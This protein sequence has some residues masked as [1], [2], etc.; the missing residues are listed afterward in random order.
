VIYFLKTFYQ[1]DYLQRIH[2]LFANHNQYQR[3]TEA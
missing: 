3:S 2:I 1:R